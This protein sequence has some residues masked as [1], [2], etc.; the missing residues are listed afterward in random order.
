MFDNLDHLRNEL[1]KEYL[2]PA[3]VESFVI[4]YA[5]LTYT[6]EK[7]SELQISTISSTLENFCIQINKLMDEYIGFTNSPDYR[8]DLLKSLVYL[9]ADNRLHNIIDRD[10]DTIVYV[11]QNTER[12]NDIMCDNANKLHNLLNDLIDT[13]QDIKDLYEG[14]V[15]DEQYI[16]RY[17]K[18]FSI[19]HNSTWES[20]TSIDNEIAYTLKS[21]KCEDYTAWK[22]ASS[23]ILKGIAE[24]KKNG[25]YNYLYDQ[26]GAFSDELVS[27]IQPFITDNYL[28]DMMKRGNYFELS[29]VMNEGSNDICGNTQ[30]M[31]R[32]AKQLGEERILRCLLEAIESE[33]D[34]IILTR[35]VLRLTTYL[36]KVATDLFDRYY[37][38]IAIAIKL[39]VSS[40]RKLDSQRIKVQNYFHSDYYYDTE[41]INISRYYNWK[42]YNEVVIKTV[43]IIMQHINN[44]EDYLHILDTYFKGSEINQNDLTILDGFCYLINLTPTEVLQ[45]II[46][47]N[48]SEDCKAYWMEY[49]LEIR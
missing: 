44:T 7:Y 29:M 36:P 45:D 25:S 18:Y 12:F 40:D 21:L 37:D 42:D 20:I 49:R 1:N 22:L 4:L 34:S 48:M 2:I 10:I 41:I 26:R 47:T 9:M 13:I 23:L 8:N 32:L 39:L 3:D 14:V 27:L 43:E 38:R 28:V 5:A 35:L 46:Y 15:S 24:D 30:A 16:D 17:G 31:Q 33:T 19:V 11:T 6:T